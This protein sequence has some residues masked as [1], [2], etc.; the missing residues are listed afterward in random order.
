MQPKIKTFCIIGKFFGGFF[1]Y[2]ADFLNKTEI[3]LVVFLPSLQ[4]AESFFSF[5][6]TLFLQ[7]SGIS[8]EYN[9]MK[10]I[11]CIYSNQLLF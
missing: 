9:I 6:S 5:G 2:L 3:A 1:F 8:I 7:L 4:D 11:N 10:I